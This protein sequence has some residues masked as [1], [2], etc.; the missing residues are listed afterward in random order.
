M[1]ITKRIIDLTTSELEDL[2]Y[3]TVG[4]A[5]LTNAVAQESSD[6]ENYLD[7]TQ[8]SGYLKLSKS[9][10]YRHV[11]NKEIPF[12]KSGRKLLFK[13]AE[14]SEWVENSRKRH[15]YLKS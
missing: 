2:I 3:L 11:G 8:A 4:K 14:L 15:K 1:D 6:G 5:L 10:I 12:Y 13:E 7:I 9:T